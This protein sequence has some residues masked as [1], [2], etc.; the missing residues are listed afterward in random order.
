MNIKGE[1]NSKDYEDW[2]SN[3][4]L[5]NHSPNAF[6]PKDISVELRHISLDDVLAR[7]Y[8]DEIDFFP[9][10]Q[11]NV[12]LWNNDSKSQLIESILL[13]FPLPAFYFDS[14]N[15]Y[16]WRVIDGLQRLWTLK[17]FIIDNSFKLSGLSVLKELNGKTFNDLEKQHQRRILQFPIV[18]HLIRPGTPRFAV[19][20]I[21]RRL[22]TGGVALNAQE[23]RHALNPDETLFLNSL[24]KVKLF[25]EIT[26]VNS[27][28]M[29]D[30]E[31]ALHF[32]AFYLINYYDYKPPMALFLDKA[33]ESISKLDGDKKEEILLNFAKS[34]EFISATL[35]KN[36]FS[37]KSTNSSHK[38]FNKALFEAWTVA[39]AKIDSNSR[40]MLLN[41]KVELE[42]LYND[43]LN[44]TEFLESISI[45][46]SSRRA[47]VIR[48]NSIEKLLEQIK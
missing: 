48:F 39:I 33:M 40:M 24:T 25:K 1:D 19:Y 43:L 10:F 30:T 20:D 26:K 38:R 18:A 6:D 3:D 34:I 31:L 4:S 32:V 45:T 12:G 15:Y 22:N 44:N 16:Q 14:S 23:I 42:I 11:R 41:K 5:S 36:A 29:E 7:I 2:E 21:F 35:G 13:N 37:K 9:N 8:R 28:R 27:K 47:V 17:S 46:T